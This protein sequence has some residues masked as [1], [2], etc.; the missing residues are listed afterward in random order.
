MAPT[1]NSRIGLSHICL[2]SCKS[3]LECTVAVDTV[4][5]TYSCT[6]SRPNFYRISAGLQFG[7]H[8]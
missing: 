8:L 6:L 2:I 4:V 3:G 7:W 1:S 5:V